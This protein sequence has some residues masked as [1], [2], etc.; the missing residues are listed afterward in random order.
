V[1]FSEVVVHYMSIGST[2]Y[3]ISNETP[4]NILFNGTNVEAILSTL[5]KVMSSIS[6]P[7]GKT[8][9]KLLILNQQYLHF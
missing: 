6:R 2:T 1:K 8:L 9:K 5:S 3:N 7:L 4:K